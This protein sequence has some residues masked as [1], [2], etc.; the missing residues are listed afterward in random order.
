MNMDRQGVSQEEAAVELR[1][2]WAAV[3][4]AFAQLARIDSFDEDV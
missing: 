1:R 3:L 4:A 2:S